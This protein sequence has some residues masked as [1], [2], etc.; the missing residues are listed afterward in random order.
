MIATNDNA[1]RGNFDSFFDRLERTRDYT[2]EEI[3][4]IIHSGSLVE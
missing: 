3:E 2:I 1:Y 4:K